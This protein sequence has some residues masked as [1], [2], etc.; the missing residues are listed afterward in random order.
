MPT[1]ATG[2]GTGEKLIR[3]HNRNAK[4]FGFSLVLSPSHVRIFVDSSDC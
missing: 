4:R 2:L 1:V 3:L